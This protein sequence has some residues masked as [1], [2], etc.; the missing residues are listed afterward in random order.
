MILTKQESKIMM[1][2]DP[3]MLTAYLNINTE[4]N[5]IGGLISKGLIVCGEPLD[6][7]QSFASFYL[8]GEGIMYF[9]GRIPYKIEG[10][11]NEQTK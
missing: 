8:T 5:A 4:V 6:G 2:F 1:S 10:E 11:G 9:D 3:V 7:N